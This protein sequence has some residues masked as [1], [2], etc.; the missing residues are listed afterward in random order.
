MRTVP[1]KNYVYYALLIIATVLLT[2]F[3]SNAY[4]NKSKKVSEFYNYSNKITWKELDEFITE[5]PD[6][7]IYIGDKYDNTNE[8]IEKKLKAK[9]EELNIKERIVFIDV[10]SKLINILNAEYKVNININKL[11]AILLFNEKSLKSYYYIN[12][13]F[14]VDHLINSEE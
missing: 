13:S 10:N 14:D 12:E 8:T 9:I 5:N 1:F 2:I 4:L 6:A 11:P 7:I 3:I